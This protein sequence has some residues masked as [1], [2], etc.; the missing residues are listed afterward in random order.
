MLHQIK[1]LKRKRFK[2]FSIFFT[3]FYR[4]ADTTRI[5]MN[6]VHLIGNGFDLRIGLKTKYVDFLEWYKKQESPS[7]I[8]EDFKTHVG[9]NIETWSN[10]EL[11]LG[12]YT[13]KFSQHNHF[14]ILYDDLKI[15]LG[16]YLEIEQ[17]KYRISSAH[18]D[19]FRHNL[20]FPEFFLTPRDRD[21]VKSYKNKF[22]NKPYNVS[23]VTF[24]YTKTVELLLHDL[25]KS[26]STR[27][28][29][30]VFYFYTKIIHIHGTFNDSMIL[31]VNDIS[32]ISN[33]EFHSED[34]LKDRLVKLQSNQVI[35]NLN[36][37]ASKKEIENADLICLYGL[38]LGETDKYWWG[39]IKE[40]MIKNS[41]LKVIIFYKDETI[42]H[43]VEKAKKGAKRREIVNR[44]LFLTET[45]EKSDEAKMIKNNILVEYDS[46]IFNI[47]LSPVEEEIIH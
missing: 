1:A 36:D 26:N 25:I 24:N 47:S 10:L 41:N 23:V 21:I 30:D 15:C 13:N 6:I 9:D 11:K 35:G 32:Q 8:V 17:G 37:Y 18:E 7:K 34:D 46:N 19:I 16:T 22:T 4:L 14:S 33:N 43:N 27:I 40:R 42:I 38:S 2:A 3:W 45:D 39:L 31:G 5:Q 44:F 20:C 29:Q 12:E 28:L